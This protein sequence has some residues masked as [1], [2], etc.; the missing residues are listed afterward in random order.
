MEILIKIELKWFKEEL[1]KK[2]EKINSGLDKV[3]VVGNKDKREVEGVERV[4]K[5]IEDVDIEMVCRIV[6]DEKVREVE[7]RKENEKERILEERK[8]IGGCKNF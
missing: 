1:E 2:K 8:I 3:E 7:C 5:I 4:K 6:E